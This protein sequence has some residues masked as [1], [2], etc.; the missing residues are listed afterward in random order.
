MTLQL[1]CESDLGNCRL[2]KIVREPAELTSL[3]SF[4]GKK[5]TEFKFLF[6]KYACLSFFPNI[7]QTTMEQFVHDYNLLD[8][9]FK[10]SAL[11]IFFTTVCKKPQKG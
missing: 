3:Q 2:S 7:T 5:Y 9:E 10:L 6:I 8:D 4:I 11:H 1:A